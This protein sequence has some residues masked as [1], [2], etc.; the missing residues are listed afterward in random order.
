MNVGFVGLGIMGQPMALHVL[1]AGFVLGVHNRTASRCEPLAAAGAEVFA[2]PAAVAERS[3]VVITIVSDTAAVE[4]VLFSANGV[5]EGLKPG[6]IVVDMS[7]ISPQ[8]TEEFAGRLRQKSIAMLDAPVSGGET[9]AIAGT[10]SIMA[11]GDRAAFDRCVPLFEAMGKRIVYCGGNGTGQKTKLVNQIVGALNL[12]ATVEGLRVAK[13]AGLNLQDVQQA[14]A[15]GAA[16]SWMLS[17]LGPK[18]ISGDFAP[19]FSIRLQTKDLR[20]AH[21]LAVQL[22]LDAPGTSLV[23][24]LFEAAIENGMENLGNQGL[25]KLWADSQ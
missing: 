1:R 15:G 22:G 2:T 14:V 16:G 8:A 24:S 9:G 11:G 13:A 25:Y 6:G 17:N 7:T 10:L 4:D 5:A 12:L 19:G 20:L 21:E 3:D 23:H 18:I